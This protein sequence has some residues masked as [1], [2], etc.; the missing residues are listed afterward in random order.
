MRC[1]RSDAHHLPPSR[2]QTRLNHICRGHD[3]PPV[4]GRGHGVFV[5][6][7][8][9]HREP[10]CTQKAQ[11]NRDDARL[12]VVHRTNVP[13]RAP[14][15][16]NRQPFTDH[17]G[18][19]PGLVPGGGYRCKEIEARLARVRRWR[20]GHH[21]QWIIVDHI[22]RERTGSRPDHPRRGILGVKLRLGDVAESALMKVQRPRNHARERHCQFMLRRDALLVGELVVLQTH[23]RFHREQVR[24]GAT[25]AGWLRRAMQYH[26]QVMR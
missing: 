4:Q 12:T 11:R 6:T 3:E 20:V 5:I 10:A 16:C 2:R 8:R 24:P 18:H 13:R 26:R 7:V 1:R 17:A 15:P 14:T 22:H 21:R 9:L 19:H 23:H 25:H